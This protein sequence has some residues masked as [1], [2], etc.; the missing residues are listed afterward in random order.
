MAK[1]IGE[2]RDEH[3]EKV[4]VLSVNFMR[5]VQGFVEYRV[6]SFNLRSSGFP[7]YFYEEKISLRV[8]V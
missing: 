6:V 8:R 4:S 3:Q 5:N 1:E 7:R 2:N